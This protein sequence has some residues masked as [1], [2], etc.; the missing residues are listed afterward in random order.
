MVQHDS[1]GIIRHSR[2]SI[3]VH[4]RR[5]GDAGLV[6]RSYFD[7]TILSANGRMGEVF[8]ANSTSST[9]SNLL[10]AIEVIKGMS[11]VAV[12]LAGQSDG[13]MKLGSDVCLC[14]YIEAPLF[15][16]QRPQ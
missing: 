7:R 11:M 10:K 13:K 4:G 1:N 9:S 3:H 15:G 5:L 12:R 14:S 16:K 8:I 6:S 2:E